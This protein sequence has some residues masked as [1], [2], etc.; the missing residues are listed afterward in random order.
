M[1]FLIG[2]KVLQE[3]LHGLPDIADI[4]LD[5]EKYTLKYRNAFAKHRHIKMT[6]PSIGSTR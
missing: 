3:P 2:G 1:V 5:A 6:L 4:H